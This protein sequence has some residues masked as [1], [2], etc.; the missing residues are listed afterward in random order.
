MVQKITCGKIYHNVPQDETTKENKRGIE[1]SIFLAQ[2]ALDLPVIMGLPMMAVATTLQRGVGDYNLIVTV[3]LLFTTIGLTT[4]ITNVLRLLHMRAQADKME[5]K[6][7]EAA[8]QEIVEAVPNVPDTAAQKG[9]H[10]VVAIRYNRVFIGLIIASMIFVFVNLAGLDSVQ[11][12][13]FAPLHQTWFALVAFVILTF[14][15]LSLEFFSVF[16]KQRYDNKEHYF[17][18]SLL[19]KSKY[20]AWLI[21]LGLYV[22]TYHQRLWLCP[23]STLTMNTEPYLCSSFS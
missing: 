22:L 21:V 10:H 6:A 19:H 7:S 13:E 12:Q 2:I 3:I 15:D 4:H 5:E 20:T 9:W 8:V 1:K 18:K 16:T 14:G 23:H 17:N 11:G